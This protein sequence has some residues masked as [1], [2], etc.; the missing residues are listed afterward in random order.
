MCLLNKIKKGNQEN[1]VLTETPQK[2]FD[3]I[4]IDTIGPSPITT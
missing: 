1:L 2:P 4:I 3:K